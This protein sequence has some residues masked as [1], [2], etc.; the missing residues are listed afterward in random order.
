MALSIPGFTFIS[1]SSV[2][3]R[4]RPRRAVILNREGTLV[5][6]GVTDPRR[7]ALVPT[8]VDSLLTL[9]RH[10][11]ALIVIANESG[12]AHGLYPEYALYI[13]QQRLRSELASHGIPLTAFYYCPHHPEGRLERYSMMCL[14]RKPAPGLLMRAARDHEIQLE[15]S[16]LIGDVLDDIESGKRAGCR[17]ILLDIGRETLWKLSHWRVPT[18]LATDLTDAAESILAHEGLSGGASAATPQST[19]KWTSLFGN[20]F[21]E[22]RP[23]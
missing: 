23:P 17:T 19:S 4:R 22:E 6:A 14:C 7:V 15:Q 21:D 11:F 8:V 18:R 16:W 2:W 3:R 1:S 10:G 9:H 13:I 5:E 20:F 12:V